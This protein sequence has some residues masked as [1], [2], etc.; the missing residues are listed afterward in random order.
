MIFKEGSNT[1]LAA[2]G[3]WQSSWLANADGNLNDILAS[4]VCYSDQRGQYVIQQT[5]DNEQ[6]VLTVPV[7]EGQVQTPGQVSFLQVPVS[8]T[9]WRVVYSNGA[10]AQN[11]FAISVQ[12]G[13][14]YL[15]MLLELQKLNFTNRESRGSSNKADELLG[16]P[17]GRYGETGMPAN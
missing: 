13:T 11:T 12:A 14:I 5:A 3:T 17:V 10:T 1:P 8:H 2:F 15:A 4:V 9:F 6:P 7:V 16:Y